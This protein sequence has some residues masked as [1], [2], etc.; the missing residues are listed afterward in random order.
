MQQVFTCYCPIKTYVKAF[1]SLSRTL[2]KSY[3]SDLQRISVL[4]FFIST[5]TTLIQAPGIHMPLTPLPPLTY[6]YSLGKITVPVIFYLL[7]ACTFVLKEAG[8]K[9]LHCLDSLSIHDHGT[10]A[11][12]LV[13]PSQSISS[14]MFL[15]FF[16][17]FS[18][19]KSPT[20]LP[21]SSL[22]TENFASYI[23]LVLKSLHAFSD[24]ISSSSIL[25]NGYFEQHS[26]LEPMTLG[27]S[28]DSSI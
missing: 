2:A 5:A 8:K 11:R 9:K 14:L 27:H 23:C 26:S 24:L 3:Q 28:I 16:H 18:L 4:S 25:G 6:L 15:H 21:P 1:L 22:S 12:P 13:L 19:L 10:Q 7:G 20:P 17:T